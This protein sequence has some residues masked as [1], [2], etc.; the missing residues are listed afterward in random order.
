MPRMFATGVILVVGLSWAVAQEIDPREPVPAK[1]TVAA[2]EKTVKNLF[3]AEYLKTKPADRTAFAK[4]LLENA[5]TSKDTPAAFYVLLRE[6]REVAAR[7]GNVPYYLAASKELASSFRVSEA[8]ARAGAVD[9]LAA[10]LVGSGASAEHVQLLIDFVDDAVRNGEFAAAQKL[11]KAADS[12]AR[13]TTSLPLALAAAE[14]A[15]SLP[16]VQKEF[17]KVPDAQKTL[18]TDPANKKANLLVGRFLCF[19]KNDWEGGLARLLLGAQGPIQVAVEKDVA[20]S[21]DKAQRIAAGDQWQKLSVT[22]DPFQKAGLEARSAYWYM[23]GVDDSKGPERAR[24]EKLIK[25]VKPAGPN[26]VELT[27]QMN[28]PEN[29]IEKGNWAH[30]EKGSHGSGVASREFA[31]TLPPDCVLQ[32]RATIKG[33]IR[34]EFRTGQEGGGYYGYFG[35]GGKAPAPFTL[36]GKGFTDVRGDPYIVKAGETLNVKLEFKKDQVT[37]SIN[38]AVIATAKRRVAPV[39]LTIVVGAGV[40]KGGSSYSDF[41]V[42]ADGK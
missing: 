29:W 26:W 39:K 35:Q 34:T 27:R 13:K 28:D 38:D 16:G 8:E 33:G 31:A 15:K 6:A 41:K 37:A 19:V 9:L 11:A 18:Q 30:D 40:H 4:T 24:I 25:S 1:D 3:R 17:E 10:S 21:A 32:F 5:E 14:R 22:V 2:A 20:A 7:A 42:S 23:Q 12:V 36:R